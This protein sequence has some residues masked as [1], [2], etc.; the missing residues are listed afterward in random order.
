LLA[1]ISVLGL[2]VIIPDLRKNSKHFCLLRE[3]SG[4][5]IVLPAGKKQ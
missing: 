3:G 2:F 5:F 4:A 1:S